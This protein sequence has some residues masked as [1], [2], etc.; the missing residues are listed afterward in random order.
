MPEF[1]AANPITIPAVAEK[2]FGK[3]AVTSIVIAW[4]DPNGP[5]TAAITF[6]MIGV[7]D[8]EKA[9]AP[10]FSPT[11]HI[12][13]VAAEA[14]TDPEFGQ[15]FAAV[16]GKALQLATTRGIMAITVED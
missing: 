14:E 7:N 16:L 15:V 4:P 3:P 5:I 8:G 11:L 6:G 12:P 9:Y 2:T 10:N 1:V 13:D